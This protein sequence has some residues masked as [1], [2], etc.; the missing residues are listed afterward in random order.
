MAQTFTTFNV[1]G[2]IYTL[3]QGINK[4]G[5]VDG[6]YM[7]ANGNHG[8]IWSKGQFQDRLSGNPSVERRHR[9]TR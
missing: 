4:Q 9:G 2:A 6:A 3:A 8:F 5:V 1:P 7:D